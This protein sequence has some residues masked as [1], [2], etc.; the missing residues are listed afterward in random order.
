[1]KDLSFLE[2][3]SAGS[4]WLRV[5]IDHH[6]GVA[7]PLF[8]IHSEK[9]SGI[10][11][12]T[13][14]PLLIDWCA[15]IGF[16][17][18]QL[19]PLNDTE[20]GI[21]PYSAVSAFALNPIFIGLHDLPHV[22]E[23]PILKEELKA[24][25]KFSYTQHIDYSKVRE[26]KERFIRNYYAI[27]GKN[28]V[29]S[30]AFEQFCKSAQYWLR[31]YAVFKILKSR[32]HWISWEIWPE[33]ENKPSPELIET[34]V[35]EEEEEYHLICFVQFLC[36][37]QMKAARD[38]ALQHKISIM[39]DIPILI[40]RDSADVWMHRDLFDLSFSAGAP[41][42]MFTDL[43]QN[44]G[45]PIYQ[46]DVI[47]KQNYQWW[48][49]RL[50]WASRYYQIYRLDHIVGFFRIWAT[51]LGLTGKDGSF[52]P[53]EENTWIDQG[54]KI[55]LMMLN[56]AD[57][58]PIGEDLGVVSPA[59]KTC[60]SALGICGTRVMRW[61]RRWN[62]DRSFIS[63]M[64][65]AADSLTTVSTHD[66]ETLQQWW[67]NCPAEAQAFAETKG[68][69]YQSS[70]SREYH[71]EILWDSHHSNSLFHI[72]FLQ[73]YLALIPGLSWSDPDD[74]RINTP[75][76][77]NEKNWCYRLRPSLEDLNQLNA[78]NRILKEL[79]L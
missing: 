45:Y 50:Q 52:I 30:K 44:W 64:E 69:S 73:E 56:A 27:F 42:D 60:L 1:M 14:L 20:Q 36:D 58:L 2:N 70:L 49:E 12:Y 3:S 62:E 28:I 57:M 43:G 61:E 17:V 7:I 75:G 59:V 11:E 53:K 35:R 29:K 74:E 47:A 51:P 23:Q 65:Y 16:D 9:S 25:P 39:G 8:S 32:H 55:M 67:R 19:L 72:N 4:H 18:I 68:W 54:Q 76:T 38:Y 26:Q 40:N 13:D 46:W 77:V 71:R 22:H 21:S 79:V 48:T 78:L 33:G 34:I 24:L 6:H 63:P 5:G 31:D 15:S 66:T 41:P 37:Q 10:G